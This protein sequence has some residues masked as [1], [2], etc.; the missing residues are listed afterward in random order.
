MEG[1]SLSVMRLFNCVCHEIL[2]ATEFQDLVY[3]DI[4]PGTG[5]PLVRPLGENGRIE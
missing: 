1:R 5:S 4:D 2:T 3:G